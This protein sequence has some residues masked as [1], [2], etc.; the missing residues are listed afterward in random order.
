[1][2]KKYI[3]TTLSV[4]FC[5]ISICLVMKNYGLLIL[6]ILGLY[7]FN[8][9][10]SIGQ[11]IYKVSDQEKIASSSLVVEGVVTSQQPFWN[12]QHTYIYTNNTVHIYKVFKGLSTV[13]DVEIV[14]EG[15]SIDGVSV[16][17]SDL[18]T[19]KPNDVG[20]FCCT[21]TFNKI[22]SPTTNKLL[23]KVYADRQGFF[24]Y[25]LGNYSAATP[26]TKFGSITQGLYQH[27]KN[28][29]GNDYKV[30]DA[31]FSPERKT[32]PN[33]AGILFGTNG[34]KITSFS[35]DTIAAGAI[36][37]PAKNTITVRGTG[38]GPNTNLAAIWFTGSDYSRVFVNYADPLFVSWS[39]TQ[40]VVK[41]PSGKETGAGT[42]KIWVENSTGVFDSTSKVLYIPYSVQT[43]TN[44]Y[45]SGSTKEVNL[46]DQNSLGGYTFT[47][48][49]SSN[50]NG[51][52]FDSAARNIFNRALT[53]WKSKTGFNAIVANASTSLQAVA[54][55]NINMVMFDN[56]NTGQE[57][58][59]AGVLGSTSC[60]TTTCNPVATSAYK[61][62]GFDIVIRSKFSAG[63]TNFTFGTC[64]PSAVSSDSMYDLESTIFHELGHTIGLTHVRDPQEGT[65]L[66]YINP[67]SV[68]NGGFP[69]GVRKISLDN[70]TLQGANYIIK[71]KNNNYGSAC[72]G[73]PITEMSPVY[74]SIITVSND[75]PPAVFPTSSTPLG[76]SVNFDLV[77]ATSNKLN[78][79]QSNGV[80]CSGK[81]MAITNNVYYAFKTGILGGIL[82]LSVSGY[83]TYPAELASCN[84][85]GIQLALYQVNSA[86][87]AGNYPAP[88]ACRTFNGDSSLTSIGGLAPNTTYLLFLEGI[89]NTKAKF[90]LKFSG[91]ALPI[92]FKSFT[93][94]PLAG[95]NIIKWS[96]IED[97]S[98]TKIV[99]QKSSDG[100]KFSDFASYNGKG[101]TENSVKDNTPYAGATYYRLL[102]TS[103]DGTKSYSSVISVKGTE[104]LSVS[105]F[106][107][108]VKNT[109]NLQFSAI[110]NLGKI[111]VKV[112]DVL[113]REVTVKAAN[114]QNGISSMQIPS[115]NLTKGFYR[116]VVLDKGNN[117][118]QK[119]NVEKQ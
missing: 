28:M 47:L 71:P 37:D 18:I 77:N 116:V 118:V 5:L 90:N 48:C 21:P 82:D 9:T 91:E 19:F 54:G 110:G 108:P 97:A 92:K 10:L 38:F 78:D 39:D 16:Q 94:N 27:I 17:T 66:P 73:S 29:V 112:F 4:L 55:D 95:Y 24:K 115:D 114:I 109:I 67:G 8:P 86:P 33:S 52:N 83:T 63:S 59:P 20:I 57:P 31:S 88:V 102:V 76:T 85:A 117:I 60:W 41:V 62:V 119:I 22:K 106:P 30:V 34:P 13:T 45:V 44:G 113:G 81:I 6:S 58:L 69:N 79:P 99:L 64:P 56:G 40:I 36:A 14:T 74:D 23:M 46:M 98:I 50:G 51:M 26:L 75:E 11:S 61:K 35:P 80:N 7:L 89:D 49:N 43:Y 111:T 107:N 104:K 96:V 72:F 68:M 25:D 101:Y 65:I 2:I 32:I 3:F 15:G 84:A 70:N 1:M 87:V 42:G 53:T 12:E 105:L 93:G 103:L 100:T